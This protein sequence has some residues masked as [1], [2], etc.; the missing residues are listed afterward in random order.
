MPS[1]HI[2]SSFADFPRFLKPKCWIEHIDLAFEIKSD[3]GTC[4]GAVAEWSDLFIEAGKKSGRTFE[5][6][7]RSKE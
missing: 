4:D 7:D 5:I 3:V 6:I 1:K 2:D